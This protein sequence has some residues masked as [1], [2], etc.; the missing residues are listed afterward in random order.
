MHDTNYTVPVAIILGGIIVALALYFAVVAR[1]PSG[2]IAI[3]SGNPSLV[4]PVDSTDHILG[5]PA[6]TIQIVEYSDFD[7]TFCKA[8]DGTLHEIIANAGA[9][10][11]VAWVYRH[12]PLIEIHPDTMKLADAAECVAKTGGNDAFWKFATLL[13]ANQP[14]DTTKLGEYAKTVG[15]PSDAFTACYTDATNTVEARIKA[16]RENAL[17]LGA[18]GTPYSLILAPGKAPVVIDGAYSYD[19]VKALIDQALGK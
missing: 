15:A 18:R 13:F 14:A 3:G 1:P 10:G 16:D 17:A 2:G 7:C 11:N 8:F 12:F 5:N 9:T 19:A 4:R 6:A